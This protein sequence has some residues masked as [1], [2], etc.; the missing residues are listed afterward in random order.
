MS[1]QRILIADDEPHIV[2]V[3]A[4]K[5]RN[6]GFVI[7]PAADGEEAFEL[8]CQEKPDLLIT[9]LQ[10]PYLSGLELCQKLKDRP[11]TASIPAIMLTARGYSLAPDDLA[12]TNIRTVMSKPFSPREL[13]ENVMSVLG[14]SGSMDRRAE[15]A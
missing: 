6:A 9:D 12:R 5:L 3:V 10:M 8:A 13:L 7:I 11:D 4:L 14:G 15:A 1:P 2:Q